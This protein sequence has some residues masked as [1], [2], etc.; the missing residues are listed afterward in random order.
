[1][2]TLPEPAVVGIRPQQL[3]HQYS[4]INTTTALQPS[5][6]LQPTYRG[7][8][9]V[10]KPTIHSPPHPPFILLFEQTEIQRQKFKGENKRKER[11]DRDGGERHNVSHLCLVTTN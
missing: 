1:M 2:P 9:D 4:T 8:S 7:G 11:A 5:C 6:L 10:G 3:P